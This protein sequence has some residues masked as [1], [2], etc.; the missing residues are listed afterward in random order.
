M[1]LHR[2]TL[3]Q[4]LKALKPVELN[5]ALGENCL[6]VEK[7]ST[8]QLQELMAQVEQLTLVN[9][10]LQQELTNNSTHLARL[11]TAM[12]KRRGARS[13]DDGELHPHDLAFSFFLLS[14]V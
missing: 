14:I 13:R 5:L 6:Q 4:P 2:G 9:N 8:A 1:N 11:E 7:M 12:Q 3:K 10:K